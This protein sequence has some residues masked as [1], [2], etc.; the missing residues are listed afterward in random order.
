MD[1]VA[2]RDALS[3]DLR[4]EWQTTAHLQQEIVRLQDEHV[5]WH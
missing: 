3:F 2:L 4:F 5:Q 1:V